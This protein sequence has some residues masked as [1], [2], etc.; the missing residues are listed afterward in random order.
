MEE[1][2]DSQNQDKRQLLLSESGPAPAPAQDMDETSL[3][4]SDCSAQNS[5]GITGQACND[6]QSHRHIGYDVAVLGAGAEV[7]VPARLLVKHRRA[8]SV[9]FVWKS[10]VALGGFLTTACLAV[11]G[12]EVP[13]FPAHHVVAGTVLDLVE[14]C[15]GSCT[16]HMLL[17]RH[18]LQIELPAAKVLM[19]VHVDLLLPSSIH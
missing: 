14:G 6:R 3:S 5:S 4:L 15:S 2:D 18:I 17:R 13:E 12:T 10:V 7:Q 1:I 9:H 11:L 8:L 19:L 16:W